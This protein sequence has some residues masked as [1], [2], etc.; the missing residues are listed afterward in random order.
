V[1]ANALLGVFDL[2]YDL[3]TGPLEGSLGSGLGGS[4]TRNTLTLRFE[5]P[6]VRRVERNLYRAALISYQRQRRF[7]MAAEDNILNDVRADVRQLRALAESYKLQA[8]AVELAYAQVDSA[9]STLVAPPDP[10]ARETAG[11]IAALT[12]QLLRAQAQLLRSQNALYT[13]WINYQVARTTTYLDL[14]MLPLDSRG[15]WNNEPLPD[16]PELAPVPVAAP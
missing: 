12:D 11:N 4:R 2:R 8:R 1:R 5:P 16:A 7:L 10:G 6:L 9:R 15:L 13:V 14:E 3:A